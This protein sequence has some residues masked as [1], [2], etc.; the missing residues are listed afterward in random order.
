MDKTL[1]YARE[2]LL[3]S[4]LNQTVTDTEAYGE[5]L[6]NEC[7]TKKEPVNIEFRVKMFLADVVSIYTSDILEYYKKNGRV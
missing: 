7:L 2:K 3:A 5:D 6:I 1:F 4:D